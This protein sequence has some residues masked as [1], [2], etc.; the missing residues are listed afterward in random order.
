M[1]N[2]F[3]NYSDNEFEKKIFI[4][5]WIK[6]YGKEEEIFEEYKDIKPERGVTPDSHAIGDIFSTTKFGKI[7]S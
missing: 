5:Y 3:S 1:N 7:N 4:Y 2:A 6:N